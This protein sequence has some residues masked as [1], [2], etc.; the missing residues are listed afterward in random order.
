MKG[1]KGDADS[2]KD[3]KLTIQEL[4][5]FAKMNVSRTAGTLDREQTPQLKCVDTGKVLIEY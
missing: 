4:Y 5:D 3:K 1:M 2:N